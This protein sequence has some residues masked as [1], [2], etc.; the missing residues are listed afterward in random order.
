MPIR[1]EHE[2]HMKEVMKTTVIYECDVDGC[3]ESTESFD[4]RGDVDVANSN[5]DV[6]HSLNYVA[7]NPYVG[8]EHK[9][10][11]GTVVRTGGLKDQTGVFLCDEHLHKA[12]E[13]LAESGDNDE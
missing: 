2:T 8:K 13:M 1:K 9:R 4:P 10:E 6:G 5:C 11:G 7:L 12:G 3:D